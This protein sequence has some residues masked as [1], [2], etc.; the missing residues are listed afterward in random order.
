M[1]GAGAVRSVQGSEHLP[2][3]SEHLDTLLPITESVRSVG[4]APKEL[5]ESTILQLCDGRYLTLE[6]L[7]SL[8]NRSKD[9]LRN[10]YINPMLQD[11][12]IEQK[13]RKI[14]ITMQI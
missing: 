2:K 6:E 9:S 3:G 11:G 10:D 7:S 5:V 4:K 1:F 12:R 14:Q 13:Y 8:L